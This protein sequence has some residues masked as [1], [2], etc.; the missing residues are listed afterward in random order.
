MRARNKAAH[1]CDLTQPI[2]GRQTKNARNVVEHGTINTG[3]AHHICLEREARSSQQTPERVERWNGFT[4][5]Y[6]SNNRLGGSR[7]S[8]E[9]A[10]RQT[11]CVPRLFEKVR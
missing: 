8:R 4:K 1:L 2:F 9:I 11:S 7:L 10:L 5:L 6:S 3:N